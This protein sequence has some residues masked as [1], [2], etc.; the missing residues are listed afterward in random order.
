MAKRLDLFQAKHGREEQPLPAT[1][2]SG[3]R[4]VS[5]DSPHPPGMVEVNPTCFSILTLSWI[6]GSLGTSLD[7]NGEVPAAGCLYP[8]AWGFSAQ[9]GSGRSRDTAQD[10]DREQGSTY[11]WR[12]SHPDSCESMP[13]AGPAQKC[14]VN[15]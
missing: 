11:L 6:C 4:A 10:E 9:C 12:F 13:A 15:A 3:G 8:E 1:S 7:A 2:V 14:L 5:W